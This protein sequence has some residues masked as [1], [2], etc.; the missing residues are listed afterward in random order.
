MMNEIQ[1]QTL[2]KIK[3]ILPAC[4]WINLEVR[5]GGK[6]YIFEVDFLKE[7]ILEFNPNETT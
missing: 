1:K 3:S 7:T 5:C 4:T 6:D 2:N